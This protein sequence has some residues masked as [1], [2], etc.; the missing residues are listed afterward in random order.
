MKV[1][2]A[3]G[4]C[5]FTAESG[6]GRD[7]SN[8]IPL[9]PLSD[10]PCLNSGTTVTCRRLCHDLR[11]MHCCLQASH[12]TE[13]RTTMEQKPIWSYDGSF[14]YE[15]G[16]HKIQIL[17]VAFK[18][19]VEP[20]QSIIIQRVF[21]RTSRVPSK[22]HCAFYPCWFRAAAQFNRRRWPSLLSQEVKQRGYGWHSG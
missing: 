3:C 20:L 14:R 6:S 18:R 10:W 22:F 7:Y 5:Q 13:L 2:S 21:G 11:V 12:C 4:M 16:V 19:V 9:P 1:P 8:S 15:L 17:S